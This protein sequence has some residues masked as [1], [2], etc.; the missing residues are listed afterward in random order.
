MCVI[1]LLLLLFEP[2][3]ASSGS[4]GTRRSY[5]VRRR[6]SRPRTAPAPRPSRGRPACRDAH[7]S[8]RRR[9][10]LPRS[11]RRRW[12][13]VSSTSSPSGSSSKETSPLPFPGESELAGRIELVIRLCIRCSS[14]KPAGRRPGG[15]VS[16]SL[17]QTNS[18]GAPAFISIWPAA[19]HWRRR[20]LSVRYAQTRSIG[21]GSRRWILNV[22]GSVSAP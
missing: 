8:R 5:S 19:S 2:P 3:S 4:G 6:L 1:A 20:S 17:R 16:S 10:A 13:T 14:Q 18:N 21:P 22:A 7:A 12:I 11:G 9:P 15:S